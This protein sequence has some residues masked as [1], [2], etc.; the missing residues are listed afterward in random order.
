M[1]ERGPPPS[2]FCLRRLQYPLPGRLHFLSC[3]ACNPKNLFN[4]STYTLLLILEGQH[5][6]VDHAVDIII[7]TL[8]LVFLVC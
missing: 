5:F 6:A 7:S 8:N 4:P 2:L 3:A 1:K